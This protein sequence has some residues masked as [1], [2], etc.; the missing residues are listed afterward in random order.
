MVVVKEKEAEK[1]A[2]KGLDYFKFTPKTNCKACGKPTCM[3]FSMDVA[4]GKIEIGKC[5]HIKPDDL[6]KLNNISASSGAFAAGVVFGDVSNA[7]TLYGEDKFSTPRGHGFSAERANHLFDAL[8]GKDAKLTGD[9]NA[10]NGADRIV[11]GVEIQSKYCASGS[12]CVNECF[13]E[14]G[15]FRYWDSK[16]GKPM[17]IEVPSDKYDAAVQAM[18]EKIRR[19]Q[20]KGVTDPNEAKNIIRK[21]LFTYEQAKNIAKA[22]TVE[23]I[24]FDAVNGAIIATCAFGLSATLSFAVALWNGEKFEKAIKSSAYAGLKVGGVT[25][26]SAILAGQLSKAGLNSALVGGSEAIISIM[27]PKASALLVNAF[28]SGAN[29][30]G[31]AAMKSAAK[32]LR[33]NVITGIAT[34]AVLSAV[35]VVNIFQGRISGKQLFKN[36]ATTGATVAGGTAGWVG[37]AAAGAALGSAVPI[38]GNVVGGIIGGIVGSFAVGAASSKVSNAVFGAF[39]EDDADEMVKII[40][41]VFQQMAEDYFL[42]QTEA[43]HIVDDLKE[44]LTGKTLKDMFESSNRKEFAYNLLINNVEKEFS[45]RQYIKLP[46]TSEMVAGLKTALEEIADND[47]A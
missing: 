25:F 2:L 4:A 45:K 33:G 28:R 24:T 5:P 8:T 17:Q 42:N 43:E 19:G 3:A 35:D 32:L 20:V 22:G 18:E 29:I 1:M 39:I 41:A 36:I 26:V 11:D 47:V 12:K 14:N 16:T 31:A 44:K 7:A 15:E 37:G 23:S 46:S 6:K 10:K 27:G 34:V 21:G 30:Y 9:D 40:E 13:S 38:I